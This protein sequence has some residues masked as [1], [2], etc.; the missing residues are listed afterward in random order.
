MNDNNKNKGIK[1]PESEE[2]FKR[3]KASVRKYQLSDKGKIAFKK[4]TYKYRARLR[5]ERQSTN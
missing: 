1:M 3:R 5:E 4:A 2:Q